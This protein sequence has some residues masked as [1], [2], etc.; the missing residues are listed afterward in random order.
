MEKNQVVI[1]IPIYQTIINE[2]EHIS[3]QQCLAVL[4]HYPIVFVA[5][6]SLDTKELQQKYG[7]QTVVRFNDSYFT[8][9]DGYNRLMLSPEFY[10][11]FLNYKYLLICQLDVYVFSDQLPQWC[12]KG[13]DYIGA[14]WVPSVKYGNPFYRSELIISQF[15]FRL[16]SIN[17]SRVNYYQTGNGGFS[18][19]NTQ[20]FFDVASSDQKEIKEFL[21]H[22]SYHYAED[23]YWGIYANRK[24]KR[25]LIP[26]YKVSMAFAFENHPKLLYKYNN[27]KLP[28]G[29]H[30]WYKEG[31]LDFW[32][33]FIP[34]LLSGK[35]LR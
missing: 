34:Q 24:R 10:E 9:I 7:I 13:Y 15:V 21:K 6:E 31:R 35:N 33:H 20:V 23:V 5:P 30:A 32:R 19:R 4:G 28:F 12:S 16:L 25:I 29:A 27:E 14:P 11:R 8:G 26:S 22:Q 1:V 18:L 17:N 3:L 2:F